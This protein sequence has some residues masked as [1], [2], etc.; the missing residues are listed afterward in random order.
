[1]NFH[2]YMDKCSIAE[3]NTEWL[4][5][6]LAQTCNTPIN[7]N[8]QGI[9]DRLKQKTLKELRSFL[10]AVNQMNRF[11][12]NLAQLCFPFW[13]SLKNGKSWD[14]RQEHD[15][16]FSKFKDSKRNVA[17]VT[18]FKRAADLRIFC[19]PS[20]TGLGA[21]LQQRESNEERKPIHFA[22]RFLTVLESK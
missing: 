13:P 20:R 3:K 19:D 8:V 2:L 7:I 15:K 21:V 6:D 9:T 22:S 10:G 4:G 14:W 16:V 11:V 1:M 18:H 12:P 17:E 5:F